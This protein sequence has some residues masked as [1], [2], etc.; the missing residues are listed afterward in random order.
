MLYYVIYLKLPP[1]TN[2]RTQRQAV[3]VTLKE[4]ECLSFDLESGK[5][6]EQLHGELEVLKLKYEQMVSRECGLVIRSQAT[7]S[8][9]R[10]RKLKLKYKHLHR[11]STPYGTLSAGNCPGHPKG[12]YRYRNRVGRKASN[13]IKVWLVYS[14]I[15]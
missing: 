13:W 15:V 12:D 1:R 14:C 11:Q 4:L 9:D 3:R 7:S 10:A 2:L 5:V 6:L 8:T